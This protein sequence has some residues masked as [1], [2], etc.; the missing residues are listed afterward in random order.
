M[1]GCGVI[2]TLSGRFADPEYRAYRE[3]LPTPPRQQLLRPVIANTF[4]AIKHL[5]LVATAL[6]LGTCWVGGFTDASARNFR[7][8][9]LRG[10]LFRLRPRVDIEGA[11]V[12]ASL[13]LLLHRS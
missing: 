7:A 5:V 4:I 8:S 6:G 10:N 1:K 12:V 2:A 11:L 13:K 3:S 9:A